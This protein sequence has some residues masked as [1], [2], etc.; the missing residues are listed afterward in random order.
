MSMTR[1]PMNVCAILMSTSKSVMGPVTPVT[2]RISDSCAG[3]S[4]KDR[5]TPSNVTMSTGS[6]VRPI[7]KVP[8]HAPTAVILQLPEASQQRPL[9][10]TWA[11]VV[12][13][14]ANAL[15]ATQSIAAVRLQDPSLAEQ[16]APR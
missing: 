11:H 1:S 3:E 6:Q 10:C 13:A 9:H 2:V 12:P 16:Q 8:A 4:G 14:P 5:L 7:V 15:G